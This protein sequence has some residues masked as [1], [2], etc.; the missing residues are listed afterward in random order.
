MK[1]S[2]FVI[3]GLLGARMVV[4]GVTALAQE[5]T[6]ATFSQPQP[7]RQGHKENRHTTSDHKNHYA[8]DADR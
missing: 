1:D 4:L 3:D 2:F 8:H 5:Q 6:V 7:G